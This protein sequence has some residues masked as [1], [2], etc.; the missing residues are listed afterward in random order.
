MTIQYTHELMKR[1][2]ENDHLIGHGKVRRFTPE[3]I[4]AY[5]E[6]KTID[7]M[8]DL[9]GIPL[10][11]FKKVELEPI[12]FDD[13][14]ESVKLAEAKTKA[15]H[16][17]SNAKP[18]TKRTPGKKSI[19]NAIERQARIEREFTSTIPYRPRKAYRRASGRE[20]NPKVDLVSY[21]VRA[22]GGMWDNPE[23]KKGSL[24]FPEGRYWKWDS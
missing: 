3:E 10:Q 11:S 15:I 22:D 13:R 16:A 5:Q 7:P 23:L 19:E 14:E 20:F 6:P 12:P 4:A 24:F 17:S 2:P 8:L 18:K 21:K 9:G 1:H